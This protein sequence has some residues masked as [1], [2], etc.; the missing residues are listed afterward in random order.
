MALIKLC[1]EPKISKCSPSLIFPV[2]SYVLE[3][4][5]NATLREKKLDYLCNCKSELSNVCNV[6]EGHCLQA[7]EIVHHHDDGCFDWLIS[8]QQSVNT[9]REAISILSGEIQKI[10]VCQSCGTRIEIH[11]SIYQELKTER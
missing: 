8:G 6:V 2:F 3:Q 9:S 11:A 1:L 10:Y 7:M 5:S 4:V